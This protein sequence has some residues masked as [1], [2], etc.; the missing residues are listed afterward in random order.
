MKKMIFTSMADQK[1]MMDFFEKH[2]IKYSWD[3]MNKRYEL[4]LGTAT[5]DQIKTLLKESGM[6]VQFKWGDYYW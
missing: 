2:D 6:K 5:S 3:F 4:H 1:K